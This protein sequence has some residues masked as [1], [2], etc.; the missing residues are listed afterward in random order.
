MSR[1]LKHDGRK[2]HRGVCALQAM[3]CKQ[4]GV[5]MAASAQIASGC[6]GIV[7]S[8]WRTHERSRFRPLKSAGA[9]LPTGTVSFPTS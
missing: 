6:A 3:R 4:I 9:V 7:A 1:L 2:A 8:D 5:S